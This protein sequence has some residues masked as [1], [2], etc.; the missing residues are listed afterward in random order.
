[1]ICLKS[2]PHSYWCDFS[3]FYESLTILTKLYFY[4]LH[5]FTLWMYFS[6]ICRNYNEYFTECMTN[7]VNDIPVNC[8]EDLTLASGHRDC[9]ALQCIYATT[10]SHWQSHK[11][12]W[13]IKLY[14][15]IFLSFWLSIYSNEFSSIWHKALHEYYLIQLLISSWFFY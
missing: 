14:L 12:Q 10:P 2:L 13:R 3:F 5:N 9:L 4:Q 8:P 15:S 7:W 1:M 6:I 11:N